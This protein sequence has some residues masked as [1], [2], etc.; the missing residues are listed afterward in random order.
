M[1]IATG[2]LGPAVEEIPVAARTSGD[3]S[4][5][6]VSG[7]VREP[8]GL[9]PIR[10]NRLDCRGELGEVARLQDIGVRAVF[11]GPA[12]T[13]VRIQRAEN[14]DRDGFQGIIV[15]DE[16]QNLVAV[17]TRQAQIQQNEVGPRRVR[18]TITMLQEQESLVTV[19]NDVDRV[20]QIL[21]CVRSQQRVCGSILN[22]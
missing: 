17:K 12:L 1:S 7:L 3:V 15:L 10:G 20:R 22:L 9:G 21:Q 16:L 14:D 2:S 13:F 18:K 8:A 19:R 6:Y 4:G 11:I 5:R